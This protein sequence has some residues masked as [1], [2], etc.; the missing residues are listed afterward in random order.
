MSVA[1][2]K[3]KI[4]FLI[5]FVGAALSALSAS[6]TGN[7]AGNCHHLTYVSLIFMN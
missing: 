7:N 4:V 2:K 1:L 5:C 6:K 3:N